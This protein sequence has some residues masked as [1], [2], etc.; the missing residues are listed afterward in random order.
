MEGSGEGEQEVESE[1][2]TG[3]QYLYLVHIYLGPLTFLYTFA[4]N[5]KPK[6]SSAW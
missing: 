1:R 3:W 4:Q 2:V 5:P 6:T